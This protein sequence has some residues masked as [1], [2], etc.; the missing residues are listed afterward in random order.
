MMDLVFKNIGLSTAREDVLEK[1]LQRIASDTSKLEHIW[2]LMD[3]VWD[4]C[5][6]DNRVPD[7]KKLADFYQHPVWILNGLL[8][9]Q[10][11]L[12]KQHREA[13][14]DWIV[15]N[16]Y[17][18]RFNKIVDYG[19]GFGT[20]ARLVARKDPSIQVD[21]LEPH[22]ENLAR[23]RAKSFTNIRY[24]QSLDQE[25]DCLISTDVLEHLPD[26]L[27]TLAEMIDSVRLNGYLLIATNFFPVIKCHLPGTF[28]LR[29]TF[30]AFARFFGLVD[31]GPCH[32]S[33]TTIYCKASGS[34]P[35]WGKIRRREKISKFL[36]P[37]LESLHKIYRGVRQR[38]D[39][40]YTPQHPLRPATNRF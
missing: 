31:C 27:K 26:P 37:Y 32:G 4:E 8:I 35:D 12:S 15:S 19:G 3:R 23:I 38:V 1:L 18:M 29:Y 5:G 13:I 16:R 7:P 36:F 9:E 21:V 39:K 28:H 10:H 20:L 30:K 22:P 14:S 40:N 6:C 24:I 25:Y 33:H 17:M 2:A 11:D 34:V